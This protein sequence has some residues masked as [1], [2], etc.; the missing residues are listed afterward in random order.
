MLKNGASPAVVAMALVISICASGQEIHLKTRTFSPVSTSIGGT[1]T[2]VLRAGDG[3]AANG[4]PGGVSETG[5]AEARAG[6]GTS[7]GTRGIVHRI[8]EFDHPPGVED[9]DALLVAGGQVT[10]VLPDNAVMISVAG[11]LGTLPE[12]AIWS[13]PM[14]A[15]DKISPALGKGRMA[16]LPGQTVLVVVEFHTDVAAVAQAALATSLG[17]TFLH[18]AGLMPKHAMVEASS[19]DV[20]RLSLEDEVAYVFP[21]DSAMLAGTDTYPCAGMLTSMGMVAQYANI[22]HG[23][24][25][26]ADKIA[27]LNYIFGSLTPKVPAASVE[28]EILRAFAQWAGKVNVTFQPTV[29][30]GLARTILVEFASGAHGDSY[31]F[32]GPGGSL[33]HTFYPA[34]VNSEPIAGDMHF[35]ADEAWRVGGDTDIY[36]V[37]LHEAGHALGLSHSDN[38]G[39]VMYPYYRRGSVLSANDIGAALELYPAA[40]TTPTVVSTSTGTA[41][42]GSGTSGTGTSG[43]STSG[44]S[45][46]GQP[47]TTSGGGT[48]VKLTPLTLTLNTVPSATQIAVIGLSGSVTGGMNTNAVVWQTDHGYTGKAAMSATGS[49]IVS[50]VPLVTGTNVITVTAWN[51]ADQYS[52][53]TATVALQTIGGTASPVAISIVAPVLSVVSTTASS[54]SVSGKATGG[55]GITQV[56][57][58][59]SNGATGTACGT[60]AWIANGIALPKGNTTIM[61]RAFDAKGTSAW[62]SLVVVRT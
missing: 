6:A 38:P 10:G 36:T 21:A 58:Q 9:L 18:P 61:L 23:W 4:T 19:A 20:A 60:G 35:D 27:H 32:D 48:T 54:I 37:A 40:G 3:T 33:G 16:R 46:S 25:V 13:G 12:G 34:P 1:A 17:M 50:N 26:G 57:W 24:D 44:S 45:T 51:T 62:V 47:G 39:D 42:S 5:G 53:Q 55:A 8:V 49:W 41:S 2:T 15:E 7:R 28:S 22:T 30:A 56:T 11:Q 14:V 52:T 31:P 43:T 59:T 29:M